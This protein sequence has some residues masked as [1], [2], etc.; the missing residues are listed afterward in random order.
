MNVLI[1]KTSSMG[2]LI[3]TLPALTD[4]ARAIPNVRF[5]WVAEET[6]SEIPGWH[7]AVDRVIPVALRRWRQ[8]FP[9]PTVIAEIGHTVKLLRHRNYDFV[10]DL[11]GLIKS[12]VIT[13][14]SRGKRYGMDRKSC[15][16]QLSAIAYR[17]PIHVPKRRHAI[18]RTR[19]LLGA[20]LGY[21]YNNDQLDYGLALGSFSKSYTDQPYLVFLHGSS[22][23]KKLWETDSWIRLAKYAGDHGF[24]VY[25]PR[26]NEVEYQRARLLA[27]A[28]ADMVE[29]LPK[30][31]L[32]EL[33]AILAH[34]SGV[35]GVDTGLSHLAA[36]LGVPGVT[37]YI[38][39]R[40]G[41]TGARGPKQTCLHAVDQEH[42]DGRKI[43][44]CRG[45]KIC[46]LEK[47][48]AEQVWN[49]LRTE[50]SLD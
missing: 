40:P 24:K 26:H 23:A 30:L 14:I 27:K 36:A 39:S 45:L 19:Q 32:Q 10:I 50:M 17:Y 7:S 33:A 43:H 28:T 49:S 13:R 18:D 37:L 48:T 42:P 47:L 3:H 1:V 46:E 41:L 22:A 15:K 21:Q 34:A 5:D 35:V 4:A 16:E 8:R 25:V 9:T 12:A 2:D 20:A 29:I 31:C 11:Q 44:N 6:F 38:A